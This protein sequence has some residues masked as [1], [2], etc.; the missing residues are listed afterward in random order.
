MKKFINDLIECI[1]AT[2][3][4]CKVITFVMVYILAIQIFYMH[5]D[6]TTLNNNLL[7]YEN[8]IKC[9]DK[10]LNLAKKN[11]LILSQQINVS[12]MSK[13]LINR[14]DLET[15]RDDMY[16][17]YIKINNSYSNPLSEE[18]IWEIITELK[19]CKNDPALLLAI[20]R[21]ESSFDSNAVSK[22]GCIGLMQINPLHSEK[23]KFTKSDLYDPIKSIR[24]A[25][26]LI[27]DW[28]KDGKLTTSEICK[29]YLGCHSDKYINKIK[30][31]LNE[32]QYI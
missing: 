13:K 23:Y 10:S 2:I 9:L 12:N 32:L 28:Q 16:Y 17:N 14:Y 29:K 3:D 19:N 25:D 7:K 18:K 4:M 26:Q 31:N 22:V 20:A 1:N 30:N 6:I 11:L 24:I 15:P 5:T 27:S 21:A 8:E